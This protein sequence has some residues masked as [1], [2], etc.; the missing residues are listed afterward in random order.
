MSVIS[1]TVCTGTGKL[2]AEF[3]GSNAFIHCESCKGQGFI[4]PMLYAPDPFVVL[5]TR[6]AALEEAAL[7]ADCAEPNDGRDHA[8]C[9][10]CSIAKDIRALKQPLPQSH[11]VKK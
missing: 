9:P 10:F 5:E 8:E 6:N 4:K 7:L 1:C 2:H 3:M 11:E